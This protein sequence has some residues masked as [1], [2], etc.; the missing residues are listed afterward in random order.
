[1]KKLLIITAILL[2]STVVFA[3][4]NP[5]DKG[6]LLLNGNASFTSISGD[7]LTGDESVT[8]INI[9]PSLG[10]FIA[11]NIMIG[12]DLEY[13]KASYADVSAS[14]FGIGPTVG[15]YFNM[16]PMRMESKGA[17]FPYVKGFFIWTTTSPDLDEDIE[18]DGEVISA[19]DDMPKLKT[20]TYGL[21]GG[22][23]FMLSNSVGADFS[24]RYSFD[25]YKVDVPD[26]DDEESVDGNTLNIGVG[27]TAFIY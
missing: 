15:Y 20:T 1:M 17:I 5:T 13:V 19:D 23:V 26:V 21:E 6:S 8:T 2:L 25:S 27:I 18:F 10:Y 3:A 4:E 14:S 11:P 24:L 16:D 9:I 7:E 12:A 22:L